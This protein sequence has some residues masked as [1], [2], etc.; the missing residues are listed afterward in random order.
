MPQ[1]GRFVLNLSVAGEDFGTSEDVKNQAALLQSKLIQPSSCRIREQDEVQA[2]N[3]AEPQLK[4]AAVLKDPM[5][6]RMR[7][8]WLLAGQREISPFFSLNSLPGSLGMSRDAPAPG[9]RCPGSARLSSL[10]AAAPSSL[11]RA[12]S[13]AKAGMEGAGVCRGNSSP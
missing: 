3:R 7:A 8:G 11:R 6:A 12:G 2:E 4:K 10:R 13:S 5:C 1:E 9:C